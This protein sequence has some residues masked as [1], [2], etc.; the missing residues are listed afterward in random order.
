MAVPGGYSVDDF[1]VEDAT[2]DEPASVTCPAGH[3]VMISTKGR[4]SFA[5]YC[6]TCPL[7]DS[8]TRSK[9]G[10][11]MTFGPNHSYARAQLSSWKAEETKADYR[12]IRLGA[13][14]I[15]AQMK[16]KLNGSKLC[17]RS[18]DK[19]TMHFSSLPREASEAGSANGGR[20]SSHYLELPRD[21]YDVLA[22]AK[23]LVSFM[24]ACR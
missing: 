16:R 2:N 4:A 7:L 21:L 24:Q 13:E 18:L 8:C 14:R 3:T 9:R 23:E 6:G 22:F 15:H 19:N 5:K 10:R 17:Y 11:V 1:I 20:S 12:A